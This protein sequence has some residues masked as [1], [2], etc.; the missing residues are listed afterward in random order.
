[1]SCWNNDNANCTREKTSSIVIRTN[2]PNML[3]SKSL[4]IANRC[5]FPGLVEHLV[6]VAVQLHDE[7]VVQI[8]N[9]TIG[10]VDAKEREDPIH[11][12]PVCN[13]GG[14]RRSADF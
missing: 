2:S 6:V 9:M 13:H 7:E 5:F 14:G 11:S 8:H 10:L 4:R 1:M 12:L 3:S